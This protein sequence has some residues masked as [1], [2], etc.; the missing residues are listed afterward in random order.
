MTSSN[1]VHNV[2]I[3]APERHSAAL[4]AARRAD[5]EERPHP[6]AEIERARMNKQSF[7]HVL[8]PAP[9]R[10]SESTGLV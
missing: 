5:T 2:V 6:E 3:I 4:E 8:A 9:V 7:E 1:S 10:S